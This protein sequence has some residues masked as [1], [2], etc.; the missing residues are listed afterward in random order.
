MKNKEILNI[1]DFEKFMQR[2]EK[3]EK[4]EDLEE[5]WNNKSE[6]FFKRTEKKQDNFSNRLIFKLIKEKNY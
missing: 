5:F 2:E 1:K 3:K 6:W 4:K